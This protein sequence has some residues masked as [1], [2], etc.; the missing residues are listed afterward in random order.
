MTTT[1]NPRY[2]LPAGCQALFRKHYTQC[3]E[4]ECWEWD[5]D[6]SRSGYG[7]FYKKGVIYHATHVALALANKL[8]PSA[9]ERWFA[10]HTCDHPWR[11]NPAH[12]WWG[13]P[14]DNSR[15]AAIKGRI[16]RRGRGGAGAGRSKLTTDQVNEVYALFKAGSS[17]ISLAAQFGISRATV[18]TIVWEKSGIPIVRRPRCAWLGTQPSGKLGFLPRGELGFEGASHASPLK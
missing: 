1:Y 16:G 7:F 6:K 12:L 5:G 2:P 15:D 9:D 8:P 17:A 4:D 14:K 3:G 10:C 13:T 11:V 18:Y